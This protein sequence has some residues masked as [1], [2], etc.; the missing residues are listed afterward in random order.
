MMK[1]VILST[2]EIPGYGG[3]KGPVLTPQSYDLHQVLKMV[4]TG[5]DVREVMENGEYRKVTFNDPRV[6]REIDKG[7]NNAKMSETEIKVIPITPEK[8]D[9]KELTEEEELAQI[10]EEIKKMEEEEKKEQSFEID[11]LEEL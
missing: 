3:I 4:T 10:E 7:F 11:D 1:F 6:I 9:E 2:C 5:L 8:S